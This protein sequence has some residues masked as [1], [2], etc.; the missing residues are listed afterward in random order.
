LESSALHIGAQ[1]S[2]D[3]F[4]ALASVVE[5][6]TIRHVLDYNELPDVTIF[7]ALIRLR[8]SSLIRVVAA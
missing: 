2:P 1:L 5:F 4:S 3:D 6:G 7:E 8:R